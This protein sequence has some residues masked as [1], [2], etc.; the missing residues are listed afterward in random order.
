MVEYFLASVADAE[1]GSAAAV[2]ARGRAHVL[3]GRPTMA[4][5]LDDWETS[6]DEVERALEVG[7]L[8]AGVP[9][10]EVRLLAPVPRP[11]NVYMIGANYAAHSREMHHLGPDDDV[12]KPA[13]GPFVFLKPSTTVIGPGDPIK[14]AAGA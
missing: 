13:G 10:D 9:L 3:P 11:P 5:L 4:Q 12:P 14:I 6:L 1:H 7:S 8:D 2:V